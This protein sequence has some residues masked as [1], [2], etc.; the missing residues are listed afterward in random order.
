ML[1][2]LHEDEE[3]GEVDDPPRIRVGKLDLPLRSELVHLILGRGQTTGLAPGFQVL[4]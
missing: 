4:V 1:R 2:G 3:A